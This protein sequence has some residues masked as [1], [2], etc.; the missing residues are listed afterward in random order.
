MKTNQNIILLT[1]LK[2]TEFT[3]NNFPTS[4]IQSF[5]YDSVSVACVSSQRSI[6]SKNLYN[7]IPHSKHY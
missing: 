4:F 7:I 1:K 3:L 6:I 5:V 2:A